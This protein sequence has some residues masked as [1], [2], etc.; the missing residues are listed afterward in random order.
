MSGDDVQHLVGDF[1]AAAV[2]AEQAGFDGVEVHG[3]QGFVLAEF[4]DQRNRR[5]DGYGGSLEDRMRA[6]VEVLAGIRAATGDRFQV[7]IRLSPE[8]HGSPLAEGREVARQIL[9][10]GVVDFVDLSLR[11]VYATAQGVGDDRLLIDVFTGLPRG[12]TV[13]S[14]TGQVLSADDCRSGE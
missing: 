2:R 6:V 12:D 14:V 3:A 1:V 5:Q 9:T 13:L 7:G 4:F 10:G 11:D 8:G